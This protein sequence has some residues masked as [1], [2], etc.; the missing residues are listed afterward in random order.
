[1]EGREKTILFNLSGHG[2]F[3]MSAYTNYLAGNLHDH[4][5]ADEDIQVS[6]DKLEGLPLSYTG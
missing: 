6:L 4:T 2:Y 3:D 5:L 1:E